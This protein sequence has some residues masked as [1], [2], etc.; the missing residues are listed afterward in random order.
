MIGLLILPISKCAYAEVT[1]KNITL[2]YI[3]K[4]GSELGKSKGVMI[5]IEGS[6]SLF[7]TKLSIICTILFLPN[8]SMDILFQEYPVYNN[9]N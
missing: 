1:V 8:G 6:I 3:Q 4:F 7:Q 9:D 2:H 5:Q